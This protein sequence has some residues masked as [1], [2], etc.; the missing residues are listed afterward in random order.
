[1]NRSFP[2]KDSDRDVRSW[3]TLKSCLEKRED[4]ETLKQP[5]IS[6][7]LLFESLEQFRTVGKLTEERHYA[8]IFKMCFLTARYPPS[9]F[10]SPPTSLFLMVCRKINV[11]E[12]VKK[13]SKKNKCH[14]KNKEFSHDQDIVWT[15]K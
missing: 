5:N 8:N 9:R 1:M 3:S 12:R 2:L 15:T 11:I 13:C 7:V 10:K 6:S 4:T 14:S